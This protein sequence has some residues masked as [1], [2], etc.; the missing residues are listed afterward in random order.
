MYCREHFSQENTE[1]GNTEEALSVK[2]ITSDEEDHPPPGPVLL[3]DGMKGVQRGKKKQP[4]S[5]DS[6]LEGK[7]LTLEED[8][9]L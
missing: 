8:S 2:E 9:T 5:E 7:K 6:I 3:R 4:T 1:A